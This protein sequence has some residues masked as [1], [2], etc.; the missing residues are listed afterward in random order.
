MNK[1][2]IY[3]KFYIDSN[4]NI[5]KINKFIK[6][7]KIRLDEFNEIVTSYLKKLKNDNSNKKNINK[8]YLEYCL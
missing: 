7:E 6:D 8:L 3:L 2:E 4:G 5:D 1:E